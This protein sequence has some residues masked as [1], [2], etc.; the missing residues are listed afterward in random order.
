MEARHADDAVQAAGRRMAYH[1]LHHVLG[2]GV[3]YHSASSTG[4]LVR[5]LERGTLSPCC[6]NF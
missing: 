1:G 5:M 3:A 2:L 6:N 4:R